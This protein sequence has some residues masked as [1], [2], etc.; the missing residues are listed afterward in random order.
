MKLFNSSERPPHARPAPPHTVQMPCSL[1]PLLLTGGLLWQSRALRHD[2]LK[3]IIVKPNSTLGRHV[4]LLNTGGP[5]PRSLV[6]SRCFLI[7]RSP[8]RRVT[9]GTR[10]SRSKNSGRPSSREQKQWLTSLGWTHPA[11]PCGGPAKGGWGARPSGHSAAAI[12]T[13]LAAA[14]AAARTPA[15][16]KIWPSCST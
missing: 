7:P 8:A 5:Q 1:G 3:P 15:A 2:L 10:Y 12:R 16:V 14:A 13:F 9:R 11:R 6:A 4:L